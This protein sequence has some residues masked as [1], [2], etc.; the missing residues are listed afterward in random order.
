MSTFDRDKLPLATGSLPGAMSAADKT[1]L[2]GLASGG[3]NGVQALFGG[4]KI[5]YGQWGGG[6]SGVVTFGTTFS[7]PPVVVISTLAGGTTGPGAPQPVSVAQT[8]TTG[9]H[10][11]PTSGS[12][13]PIS[14]IAIG[15]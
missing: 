2:D 5:A 15:T 3:A 11:Y 14:W 10:Y 12:Y 7:S 4:V 1:S 9:F 13:Y 6:A 8:T